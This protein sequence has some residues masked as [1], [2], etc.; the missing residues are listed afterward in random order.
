MAK[1]LLVL[2]IVSLVIGLAFVTGVV[3]VQSMVAFYVALPLGAVLLGLS[4]IFRT[5]E[6]EAAL[7]DEEHNANPAFREV[8]AATDAKGG[9]RS[10]H[11]HG[12]T[13]SAH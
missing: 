6:K 4:L 3:N 8:A 12:K 1:K 11:V 13:V 5:F 7:Y 2:S 9:V 10:R